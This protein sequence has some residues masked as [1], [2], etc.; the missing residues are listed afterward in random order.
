MAICPTCKEREKKKNQSYCEVCMKAV[1][2]KS[3]Y[4]NKDKPSNVERRKQYNA[5]IDRRRNEK[6]RKNDPLYKYSQ[7][8][9]YLNRNYGITIN[10]FEDM[11]KNQ[12]GK[13]AVCGIKEATHVDHNHDTGAVRQLLCN[14]CNS[15]IGMAQESFELLDRL[16]AYLKRHLTQRAGDT[17]TPSDNVAVLHK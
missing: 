3:Y 9:W 5:T 2:L 8:N 13:C 16:S 11:Y 12:N 6:R 15:S 7:K 17:A 4:K 14:T 10:Q 1:A